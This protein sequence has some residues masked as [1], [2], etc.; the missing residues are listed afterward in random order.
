MLEEAMLDRQW[1]IALMK[2]QLIDAEEIIHALQKEVHPE[3]VCERSSSQIETWSPFPCYLLGE[4]ACIVNREISLQARGNRHL[5]T[6]YSE[7]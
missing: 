1:E 5:S 3:L 6:V 2:A 4:L 7:K